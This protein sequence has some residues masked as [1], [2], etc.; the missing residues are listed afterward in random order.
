METIHLPNVYWPLII[1]Y[2]LIA[3][4]AF[5]AWKRS[6]SV[7]GLVAIFSFA[8][9]IS[10]DA[11]PIFLF[12]FA[13]SLDATLPIFFELRKWPHSLLLISG[14]LFLVLALHAKPKFEPN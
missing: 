5:L 11:A 8:C 13:E 9:L 3:Y 7:Y 4:A 2:I 12:T 14:P 10:I 1:A 6:S